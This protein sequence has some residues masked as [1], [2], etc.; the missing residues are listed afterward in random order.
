MTR[1]VCFLLLLSSTYAFSQDGYLELF[2]RDMKADK[3]KLMISAM[4]LP[5]PASKKFWEI[6]GEYDKELTKLGDRIIANIKD[7]AEHEFKMTDEKTDELIQNGFSYRE[8][9][10]SLLKKYYK[11]VKK[12]LGARIAARYIQAELQV[13][14]L[15]DARVLDAVPLVRVPK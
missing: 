15:V 13:L 6:Y 4:D 8:D 11:K 9:R 7:Y 10:M 12:E 1:L 2:R 5:E 14:T 3:L